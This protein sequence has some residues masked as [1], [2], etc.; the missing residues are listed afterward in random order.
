[1]VLQVNLRMNENSETPLFEPGHAFFKA[2]F[3][4]TA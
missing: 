1:M 3:I 2:V 4:Y